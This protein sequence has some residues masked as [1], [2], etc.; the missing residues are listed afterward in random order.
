MTELEEKLELLRKEY[1]LN[2][3]PALQA[4]IRTLEI[5][6]KFPIYLPHFERKVSLPSMVAQELFH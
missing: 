4:Q 5:G 3:T 6:L 1:I 2:P